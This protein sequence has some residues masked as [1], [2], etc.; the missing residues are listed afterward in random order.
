MFLAASVV[1]DQTGIFLAG[2]F[3]FYF[4]FSGVEGALIF[5]IVINAII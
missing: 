2:M 4:A 5:Y 1:G 3:Y